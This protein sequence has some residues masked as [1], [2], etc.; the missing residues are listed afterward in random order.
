[1][2]NY[3]FELSKRGD[4]MLVV[5]QNAL[6]VYSVTKDKYLWRVTY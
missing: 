4:L 6:G 5:Q 1:M 3:G 2:T